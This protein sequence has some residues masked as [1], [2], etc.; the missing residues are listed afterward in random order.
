M[1]GRV[2]S[3]ALVT[4]GA[5]ACAPLLPWYLQEMAR[6]SETRWALVAL[7]TAVVLLWR[8]KPAPPLRWPL[9]LPVL[10]LP[11]YIAGLVF[12][13]PLASAS[14]GV[15]LLAAFASASR[16]GTRMH[17]ALGGLLLL[18]LPVLPAL[19]THVGYPLRLLM[20][21]LVTPL[22]HAAGSEVV[23]DGTLLRWNGQV[24]AVDAAC[25]GV[26]KLWTGLYLVCTLAWFRRLEPGRTCLAAAAAVLAV[27][28]G[29]TLRVAALFYLETRV[30]AY[31]WWLHD[32]VGAAAFAL[33]A[34]L[35]YAAVHALTRRSRQGPFGEKE[36]RED[37]ERR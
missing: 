15:T 31:P 8:T 14:L 33:T 23:R 2:N 3:W 27:V 34:A 18:A 9:V 11:L 7:A 36:Q 21:I 6:E 37:A 5:L 30:R 24:L 4:L 16:L 17:P 29:N 20:S 10:L 28:A 12:L 22:L 1:A 25:S 19:H 32:G 35:I 26:K 13:P